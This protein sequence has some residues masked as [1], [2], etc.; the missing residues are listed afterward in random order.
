[1]SNENLLDIDPIFDEWITENC[2][3][4]IFPTSHDQTDTSEYSWFTSVENYSDPA[5]SIS[6]NEDYCII[7]EYFSNLTNELTLL[8]LHPKVVQKSYQ[9]EKRFMAP[10]PLVYLL[11]DGW[12]ILNSD[13]SITLSDSIKNRSTFVGHVF[14]ESGRVD[15]L[16]ETSYLKSFKGIE[17]D[18]FKAIFKSLYVAEADKSKSINLAFNLDFGT[19]DKKKRLSFLS[20]EIKIISKPS[21]KKFPVKANDCILFLSNSKIRYFLDLSWLCSIGLKVN[22]FLLNI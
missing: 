17:M 21:K 4:S 6:P 5:F 13:F 8:M 2:V 14:Q 20:K 1:M 16:T 9:N 3:E 10:Q 15:L 11:G 19:P 7:M 12:P 22:P 18:Y